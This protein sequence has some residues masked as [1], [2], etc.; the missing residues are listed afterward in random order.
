MS[1]PQSSLPD[2]CIF[3]TW[4]IQGRT[5]ERFNLWLEGA[6]TEVLDILALQ[7][8]AGLHLISGHDGAAG[9]KLRSFD[10]ALTP[11][12][13]GIEANADSE[14][15]GYIIFGSHQLEVTWVK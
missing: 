3:S 1:D 15:S 10:D 2:S 9:L 7:E 11:P 12:L 13:L 4:N 6:R 8:V 5:L 14:L